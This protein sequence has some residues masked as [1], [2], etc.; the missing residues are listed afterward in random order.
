MSID[1]FRNEYRFLSNFYNSKFV[2]LSVE[3]DTVE[4]AYQSFKAT[5]E[6][7]ANLIRTAETPALAKSI[8]QRIDIR[9]DWEKIKKSLM[10]QLVR[11]KFFQNKELAQKLLD[12]DEEELIEG[13]TWNDVF[14]GVC[15]G[16]G[17]NNLGLI[18]MQ[19]RN[20]LK[21]AFFS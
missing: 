17:Q 7:D 1:T 3:Y 21:L 4:H 14:W 13:N 2:F 20:E 6:F 9:E 15:K 5:N 11:C 16:R 12:T 10:L 8:G 18:L 19:V